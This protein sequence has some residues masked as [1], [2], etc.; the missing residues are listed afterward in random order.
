MVSRVATE[1]RSRTFISWPGPSDGARLGTGGLGF[2]QV[3]AG[4]IIG[5]IVV[6]TVLLPRYFEG[7]LVTAYA[8]LEQRFGLETRRF[9]SLVFIGP[10]APA[11]SVRGVA[12]ALPVG[13]II[14]PSGP[15]KALGMA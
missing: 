15:E 6:A 1:S 2:V 8:L 13:L 14:S 9:T 3:V 7:N 5:R 11:G 4:Y 12:T 10:R